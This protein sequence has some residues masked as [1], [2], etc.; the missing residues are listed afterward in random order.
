MRRGATRRYIGGYAPVVCGRQIGPFAR[1]PVAGHDLEPPRG[2][3]GAPDVA[4]STRPALRAAA[5]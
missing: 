2:P 1:V 4:G 3:D 5:R